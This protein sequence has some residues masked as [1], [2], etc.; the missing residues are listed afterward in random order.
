M[1]SL[2]SRFFSLF[3]KTDKKNPYN[4]LSNDYGDNPLKNKSIDNKLEDNFAGKGADWSDHYD[5]GPVAD[6][7]PIVDKEPIYETISG[8]LPEKTAQPVYETLNS[9][10][11]KDK[12]EPEY[13]TI[14]RVQKA[15]DPIYDTVS[16]VYDIAADTT[17][18]I[19]ETIDDE[20]IYET[21]DDELAGPVY[22]SPVVSLKP[23]DTYDTVT[24]VKRAS[25]DNTYEE[26]KT[27]LKII[28]SGADLNAELIKDLSGIKGAL[29]GE[30]QKLRNRGIINNNAYSEPS[31]NLQE[32]GPMPPEPTLERHP[33][34]SLARRPLPTIPTQAEQ[35]ASQEKAVNA[36]ISVPVAEQKPAVTQKPKTT[37]TISSVVN[38]LTGRKVDRDSAAK[39]N[40]E[41]YTSK[42]AES[43]QSQGRS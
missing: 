6:K 30:F 23:E 33:P 8:D 31:N 24:A 39:T 3:R 11:P 20:S 16:S 2:F 7:E 27:D 34:S 37:F 32:K 10:K 17:N 41:K 28:D 21:I 25:V 9:L 40:V 4:P 26:I 43:T 18:S 13:D 35:A 36:K 22:E 15:T 42:T 12:M 29:E 14:T 38:F 19:Y 1:A 5:V